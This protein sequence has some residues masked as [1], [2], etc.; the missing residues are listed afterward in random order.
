MGKRFMRLVLGKQA[1]EPFVEEWD[2][3]DE[4]ESK[5]KDAK[6]AKD[7]KPKERGK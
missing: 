7:E 2:E 6:D 1:T 3:F 4:Q 5:S